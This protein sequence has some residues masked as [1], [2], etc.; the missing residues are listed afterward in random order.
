MNRMNRYRERFLR[1]LKSLIPS[2]GKMVSSPSRKTSTSTLKNTAFQEKRVLISCRGRCLH[3]QYLAVL[4]GDRVSRY[5]SF[6]SRLLI[7]S[8]HTSIKDRQACDYDIIERGISLRGVYG[9][10]RKIHVIRS[11]ILPLHC[12]LSNIAAS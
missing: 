3:V 12:M 2:Q 8:K 5:P 10:S 6:V 7:L 4:G 11:S 1:G 9:N